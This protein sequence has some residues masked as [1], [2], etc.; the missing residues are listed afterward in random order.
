MRRLTNRRVTIGFLT[1][2]VAVIF[3]VY[4][5]FGR[6]GLEEASWIAAIVA[7]S[8]GLLTL[9]SS[10]SSPNVGDSTKTQKPSSSTLQ[11]RPQT[12]GKPKQKASV[13]PTPGYIYRDVE[14]IRPNVDGTALAFLRD[15]TPHA[16]AISS[17]KGTN[18]E[19]RE[20]EPVHLNDIINAVP[21]IGS[22]DLATVDVAGDVRFYSTAGGPRVISIPGA[23]RVWSLDRRYLL[24]A[25]KRNLFRL[26][27]NADKP[28]KL[29]IDAQGLRD[30]VWFGHRT[31]RF[32]EAFACLFDNYVQVFTPAERLP[33]QLRS[34]EKIHLSSPLKTFGS[35]NTQSKNYN[36]LRID[37]LIVLDTAGV[38][39][40]IQPEQDAPPRTHQYLIRS[41]LHQGYL[42]PYVGRILAMSHV[43]PGRGGYDIAT[44]AFV[45]QVASH[46]EFTM[47]EFSTQRSLLEDLHIPQ[48]GVIKPFGKYDFHLTQRILRGTRD[49]WAPL[50][51]TSGI[52]IPF[53]RYGFAFWDRNGAVIRIYHYPL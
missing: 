43:E 21:E 17:S 29:D 3:V 48:S 51:E 2:T 28:E 45:T 19:L 33:Y 16:M 38:A 36:R 26:E 52:A 10:Q 27:R 23:Q 18:L 35:G 53:L 15:G 25:D 44:F 1:L 31:H 5:L 14:L 47:G 39:T 50:S 12:F 34:S 42:E 30:V 40:L 46:L 7:V 20:T 32:C 24:V 49:G 41:G 13:A 9:I 22:T 4:A 11:R 37:S 8:V 6:S